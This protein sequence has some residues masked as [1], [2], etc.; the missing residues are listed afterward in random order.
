[1]EAKSKTESSMSEAVEKAINL[2]IQDIQSKLEKSREEKK[3]VEYVSVIGSFGNYFDF[4]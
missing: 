1:M 2:K 4:L 3:A